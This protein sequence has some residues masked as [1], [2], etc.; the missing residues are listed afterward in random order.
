MKD[1]L[2]ATSFIRSL[3]RGGIEV[4]MTQEASR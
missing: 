4:K 1:T 3:R 2:A